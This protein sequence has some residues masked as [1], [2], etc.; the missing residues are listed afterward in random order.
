LTLK[1]EGGGRRRRKEEE[2]EEINKNRQI[3]IKLLFSIFATMPVMFF[4]AIQHKHIVFKS[5]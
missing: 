1:R 5:L 3:F 4:G 2:E